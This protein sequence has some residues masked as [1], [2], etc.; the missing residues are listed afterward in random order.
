MICVIDYELGNVLSVKN[1]INKIGLNCIISRNENDVFN[2]KAIILPGVGSFEKG[3]NNLKKYDLVRVLNYNVI[4]KKKKILG[5]CLGFQ[6]MCNSSE[7]FGRHKG[8]SW[9]N[10]EV[11]KIKTKKFKLPHIGWNKIK[12]IKKNKILQDTSSSERLYFN[13]SYCVKKK[14]NNNFD[15]LAKCNY[16]EDFIAV[17]QQDNILGIQPHPEKSQ[18]AGLKI[19]KN[20][21]NDN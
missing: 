19:L 12:I 18:S 21:V 8:L 10:A 17:I 4:E 1:A 20:F 14:L 2:S 15:V 5:I 11:K 7:E 16:N 13:H 3:I 9:I 6:L